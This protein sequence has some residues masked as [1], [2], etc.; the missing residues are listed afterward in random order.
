LENDPLISKGTGIQGFRQIT[1]TAALLF[2]ILSLLC[3]PIF[4]IYKNGT[5]AQNNHIL[6]N[7]IFGN[8][9]LGNLG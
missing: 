7:S 2:F 6:K 9:T 4:T 5:E 3:L 8:Y 1:N